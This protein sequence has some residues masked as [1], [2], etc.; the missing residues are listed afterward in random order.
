MRRRGRGREKE[1][2]P[3]FVQ[4]P[5]FSL[6]RTE[7]PPK[8]AGE[9][10]LGIRLPVARCSGI[11]FCYGQILFPFR[12]YINKYIK[13]LVYPRSTKEFIWT[14]LNVSVCSRSNWNLK[15]LVFKARR[16]PEYPEKNLSEQRRELATNS[17]HIWR[18]LR[19]LNPGHIGGRRVLSPL[20]YLAPRALVE[21]LGTKAKTKGEKERKRLLR[22]QILKSINILVNLCFVELWTGP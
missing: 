1:T 10:H 7:A 16:K 8:L 6:T 9:Y 19:D 22:R 2:S 18:R 11:T 14:R 4:T 20:R 17:T 3:L 13:L 5:T 12:V 15:V 21:K